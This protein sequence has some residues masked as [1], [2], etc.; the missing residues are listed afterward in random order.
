MFIQIALVT[1]Y[2][3][4]RWW[5]PAI[6]YNQVLNILKWCCVVIRLYTDQIRI[7]HFNCNFNLRNQKD[8]KFKWIILFNVD[9]CEEK[10][11]ILTVYG[12]K[13][14]KFTL[15]TYSLCIIDQMIKKSI[16]LRTYGHNEWALCI[17]KRQYRCLIHSIWSDLHY[18]SIMV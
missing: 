4:N 5:L 14:C 6:Q 13:L 18:T 3:P 9:I 12:F 8:L 15:H 11:W 1:D 7:E 17:I 10:K 16:L 2:N